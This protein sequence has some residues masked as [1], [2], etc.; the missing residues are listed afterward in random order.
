HTAAEEPAEESQRRGP[1]KF[2]FARCYDLHLDSG[3]ASHS[4]HTS[5]LVIFHQSAL[6]P[7]ERLLNP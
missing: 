7:L 2:T 4:Y 3:A 6:S 1:A 5:Q